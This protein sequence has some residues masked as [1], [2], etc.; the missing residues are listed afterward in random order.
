MIVEYAGRLRAVLRTVNDFGFESFDLVGMP[1]R[2]CAPGVSPPLVETNIDKRRVNPVS[3]PSELLQAL[4][5]GDSWLAMSQRTLGRVLASFLIA[6][7]PQR[8]VALPPE[9]YIR[10]AGSEGIELV[11]WLIMRGALNE[12]VEV[13]HQ[14]YHVPASNTAV[15]HI[16]LKQS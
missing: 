5:L 11:M 9:E 12:H 7:D 1:R 10:E 4:P 8:L 13:L 6:E 3:L 14:H 2:L 16:I 15:G